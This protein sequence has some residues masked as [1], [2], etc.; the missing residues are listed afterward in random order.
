LQRFTPVAY[1]LKL[2]L[3]RGSPD[4]QQLR[5]TGGAVICR[6]RWKFR[7]CCGSESRVPTTRIAVTPSAYLW[8]N[9][10]N[11]NQKAKAEG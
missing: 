6:R 7:M 2:P 1:L 10:K 5:Q 8:L 9:N 3:E 4:P 11:R